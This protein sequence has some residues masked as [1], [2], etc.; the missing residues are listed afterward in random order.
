MSS[1]RSFIISRLILLIPMI[2]FLLTIIFI[3]LRVLPGANPIAVMSPQIPPDRANQIAEELG[4]NKP[5]HEQYF[6][7]IR[8]IITFNLGK[9][10]N[11]NLEI[12]TELQLAFGPT[13]MLG[14][15]GSLIGIPLGIIL[16]TYA[17][18]HRESKRDHFIRIFSIGTYAM[19]IFLLGT[20]MQIFMLEFL[21]ELAQHTIVGLLPGG[22]TGDF[23]HYTEIWLIDTLLS[24]RPDLAIELILHLLLPSLALGMLIAGT[25][26]RLIR[27]NMIYQLEQDYV[28]FARSRGI[29]ESTVKYRYSL[30]NAVVPTIGM[31][32][33]QFALLLSGAILT[34]TT[35][36]IPGLGR[37]IYFAIIQ[38][39]FPAVQGAF[40]ILIIVVS[41]VSLFS[42]VLYAVLDPRIKY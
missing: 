8:N 39:D 5:I 32:G 17:G 33:L 35:F 27:T 10:Y 23:T 21:P 29:P 11:S 2:W 22:A 31:I 16:G 41:I 24:G 40:I 30:K 9:S 1:L 12:I 19:P 38:K 25:I 4:L 15:F 6:D 7:F 34:E 36:S 42:D 14:T 37:Y 26:S 3:L 20:L 28:H 13:L 18:A